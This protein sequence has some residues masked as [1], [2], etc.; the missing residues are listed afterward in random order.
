MT[1]EWSSTAAPSSFQ[2]KQTAIV[3]ALVF[4]FFLPAS[5]HCWSMLAA[6]DGLRASLVV[7]CSAFLQCWWLQPSCRLIVF[8]NLLLLFNPSQFELDNRYLVASMKWS[9]YSLSY[10]RWVWAYM[11]GCRSQCREQ[12]GWWNEQWN[13]HHFPKG[14]I[15]GVQ[16]PSWWLGIS[17][18]PQPRA[19]ATP[20][21][22]LPADRAVGSSH[23]RPGHQRIATPKLPSSTTL[24]RLGEY[25]W[26]FADF[27]VACSS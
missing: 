16:I 18:P 6:R 23:R 26:H 7:F 20:A 2:H 19:A 12:W 3:E 24:T 15:W 5:K 9:W 1:V 8:K 10:L 17:P 25:S 21:M 14:G 27:N 13:A 4:F 11:K 22:C